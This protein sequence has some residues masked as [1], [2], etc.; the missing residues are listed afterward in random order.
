MQDK[1]QS[2]QDL[3]I[4]INC[5]SYVYG[6]KEWKWLVLSLLYYINL[7]WYL[8]NL[9]YSGLKMSVLNPAIKKLCL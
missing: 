4:I 9:Y 8:L 7:F 2:C 3:I 5:L 6:M 1:N